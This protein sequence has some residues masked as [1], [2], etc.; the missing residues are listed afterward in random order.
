MPNFDI[1]S[2]RANF[3][4]GSRSN[5]FYFIPAFPADVVTGDM[6]D[7]R[8][9]YLVKS[10]SMPGSTLEEILLNWQG[11]D[12][13]IAGKHTFAELVVSFNM[14]VDG[15]LRMNF[16]KWINKIHDPVTNQY[17]YINEYMTDQ[18]LHLLGYQ[19][20]PVLEFVLK[21]AWPREVAAATLD[22]T[23]SE[24]TTFDV[25]FRYAYHTISD[26]PTGL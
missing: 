17:A 22:Y 20:E 16:E 21:D 10:T 14:D 6:N 13:P 3:K 2:F 24:I 25:T 7:E 12:Y 15:F 5:L 4:D 26:R 1:D 11:M 23:A 19:G 8:T 18:R 9:V